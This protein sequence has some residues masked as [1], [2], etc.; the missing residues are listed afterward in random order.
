MPRMTGAL[1][2]MGML[3]AEG[4]RY[5]FGNPGTAE[6]AI[7]DGLERTPELEYVLATQEG[8]AMG[9]ADAYARLT[10]TVGFVN[11]HIDSGLANG[12]SL[13]TN[14]Y[15]GGSPVVV[16]S[17]NKDVRK[18]AEGRFDLA[19]MPAQ[20]TKWS[21]EVTHAE[22][23]PSVMRRAFTIARTPPTGP[24]YVGF[25]ANA[26]D[27]EGEMEIVPSAPTFEG[28][29]P[30]PA[31]IEAAAKILA[32]A[33][34]PALVVGDRLSAGEG[35]E[36]A[37]RLA[38]L[39]GAR[40][41]AT[42]HG[43]V[44]FPTGHP[45]YLGTVNPTMPAGRAVLADADAVVAL[46]ASFSGYFYFE[47]H[48][49]ASDTKFIHIHPDAAEVGKSEPTD[50]GIIASPRAAA[51]DL[52]DDLETRLSGEAREAAAIRAATISEEHAAQREAFRQRARDRWDISPMSTERM[53]SE[54][55]EVLPANALIV[56][57]SITTRGSVFGALEFN[58]PDQLLAITGG[59]LGWGMGAALGAK[60]ARPDQP[61]V[62]IVGDGSAMMT[63]QA[64]WTAAASQLPVVYLICNNESY[65]I[66]KLNMNVY[67]TQIRGEA[68]PDSKYLAMD[69]PVP[70]DIAAIANAFG[71]R[72]RRIEDPAALGPALT[73]ALA[74]NEPVVLDVRIDGSI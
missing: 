69:F 14:L 1:A 29:R 31:A 40:V 71:V 11:L 54:V 17:A 64:L 25:S 45:Q 62:A 41:Y 30:D 47:G 68:N 2:L 38:E 60:L 52:A 48:A 15:E 19:Q 49:L 39:T 55:A 70:F 3:K 66:L 27:D 16:T 50:V 4:V 51:T 36:A 37:V 46:G 72:A 57:D 53:M 67:K 42:N 33:T 21:V 18:L 44:N 61:V 34:N 74:A 12:I 65:R 56:D 13:L 24:V 22:Q 8:V 58:R 23:V 35:A 26:L 63:I 73:E 5:V 59:A 9:M 7:I 32:A 10:G 43:H 28:Q 20:F 6:S